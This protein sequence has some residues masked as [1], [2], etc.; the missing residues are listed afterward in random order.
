MLHVIDMCCTCVMENGQLQTKVGLLTHNYLAHPHHAEERVQ[1]GRSS[2]EHFQAVMKVVSQNTEPLDHPISI[3][4]V[5]KLRVL[6]KQNKV[7][8]C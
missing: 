8:E 1:D 5:D 6:R 4:A 7:D 3:I 2:E